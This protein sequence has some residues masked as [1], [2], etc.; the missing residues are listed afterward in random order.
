MYDAS[1]FNLIHV[2]GHIDLHEVSTAIIHGVQ[3][4]VDGQKQQIGQGGGLLQKH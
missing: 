3:Q 2:C 4:E 1:L